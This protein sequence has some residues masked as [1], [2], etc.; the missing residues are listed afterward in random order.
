MY[1]Y[2][3][4]YG[5]SCPSDGCLGCALDLDGGLPSQSVLRLNDL[6]AIYS[7]SE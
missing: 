3:T 6:A 4:A 2:G 7:K 5:T 1:K